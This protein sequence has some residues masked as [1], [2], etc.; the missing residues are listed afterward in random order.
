MMSGIIASLPTV[1][2]AVVGKHSKNSLLHFE[3][4]ESLIGMQKITVTNRR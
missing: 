3:T 1:G 2:F 4:T